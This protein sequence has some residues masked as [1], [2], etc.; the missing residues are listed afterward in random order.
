MTKQHHAREAASAHGFRKTVAVGKI[1][2]QGLRQTVSANEEERAKIAAFL[3]L[4]GVRSLNAEISLTRGRAK[5]VLVTGTFD[6]DVV[7]TCVVTLDPVDAKVEGEFERRFQPAEAVRQEIEEA[8]EILVDPLAEDPPEPL[9]H[10]IDL[11][12]I[13]VEELSLNLDPYPRKAGVEYHA[14][15]AEARR[16]NPFAAL[17]K[18]KPKLAKKDD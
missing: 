6:A 16:E 10:E 11:G 1:G 7:Q 5:G 12:E 14:G 2:E 13:L 9:G 4:Q 15:A 8:N 18:L 3:G 17:A